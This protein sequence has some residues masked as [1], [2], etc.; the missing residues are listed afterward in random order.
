[1]MIKRRHTC[2]NRNED[3][4]TEEHDEEYL[5]REHSGYIWNDCHQWCD[6]GH[7]SISEEDM[8]NYEPTDCQDYEP[9]LFYEDDVKAQR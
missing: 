8:D 3:C 1:M 9:D 2:L 4:P 5:E 7:G 6:A